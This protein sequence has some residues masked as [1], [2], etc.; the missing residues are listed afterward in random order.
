MK[1]LL[2]NMGIVVVVT[3]LT[4]CLT[5]PAVAADTPKYGGILRD[6]SD[7][8]P[9]RNIGWPPEMFGAGTESPQLVFDS[10]VRSTNKGVLYPWLAESFKI[11]DDYSSVTFRLR[12]NVKFH[13]GSHFNAEVAKWNL[14]QQIA[15]K[16]QPYW[17]S[18]DMLDEAHDELRP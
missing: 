8:I 6:I 18:V 13:D 17:V 2:F 5:I 9:T 12:K 3:I 15:A 10:L 7:G 16:R 4:T 14:D 11:A 1:R